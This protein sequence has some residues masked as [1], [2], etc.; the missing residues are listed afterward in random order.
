[1]PSAR[2]IEIAFG[3][4]VA[5]QVTFSSG[6]SSRLPIVVARRATRSMPVRP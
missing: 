2:A 1:M 4:D 3:I 6:T 5:F